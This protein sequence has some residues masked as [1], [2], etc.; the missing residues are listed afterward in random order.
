MD[1]A[2][3]LIL[4]K[5]FSGVAID[6]IVY[7]AEI[8]KGGFFYHFKNRNDL[9]RS[10]MVRYLEEDDRVLRELVARAESL[11]DDPLQRVLA[12]LKLYSELMSSMDEV[13]PGCLV[14]SYTYES[15]QFDPEVV[16]LTREGAESWKR[17][18]L[19]QLRP[20]L[21]T[22]E[23]DVP[24]EDLSDTLN[25]MLEGGILMSRLQENNEL[26]ARQ[27]LVFRDYVR[28]VFRPRAV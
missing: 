3:R 9:A 5:G 22:H 11:V 18:F 6:E 16:Q 12:F 25:V 28:R 15:H 1:V 20:A 8:T 21:D 23:C 27:I 2:Q 13:H 7:E 10:L 4:Q 17:L 26:L 19:E 14:A 24:L